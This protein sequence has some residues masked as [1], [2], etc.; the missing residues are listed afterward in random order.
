MTNSKAKSV[1]DWIADRV[2]DNLKH[3]EGKD[4]RT[5]VSYRTLSDYA[6]EI[7]DE[8]GRVF[9]VLVYTADKKPPTA[10]RFT[11]EGSDGSG[12]AGR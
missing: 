6:L 4:G 2:H 9:Q 7:T 1:R 10:R 5:F 3:L 8:G 12:Q 11:G